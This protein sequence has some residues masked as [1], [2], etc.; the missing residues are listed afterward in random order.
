MKTI[1]ELI[2][3]GFL[4]ASLLAAD[5]PQFQ[6]DFTD[7]PV[8]QVP[9]GFR[10]LD[11]GFAVREEGGNR[12]LELPG[13]PL[14]SYGALFGPA[15]R[16]DVRV[17][18]R[19]LSTAKGRRFPTFAVGL[20]GVSGYRLQVTPGKKELELWR[21]EERQTGVPFNW[22]SGQWTHLQLQTRKVR[23][24]RW[25]V[26]GRAWTEGQAPPADWLIA[27][28]VTEEPRNGQAGIFGSP[29]AGTPIAYDDLLVTSAAQP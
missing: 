19:I 26:E 7:A 25:K 27:I 1:R 11:G 2:L 18:A 29:F 20:G 3:G 23:D 5:A 9:A 14:E 15:Q 24:G 22:V 16:E 10:V 21:G 4:A 13:A 12:F 28:E 8:G 6:A 17:R